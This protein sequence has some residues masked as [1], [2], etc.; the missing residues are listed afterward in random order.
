M[1][2]TPFASRSQLAA[3][4]FLLFSGL[5]MFPAGAWAQA[6]YFFSGDGKLGNP[7]ASAR[8]ENL[9]PRLKAL[10][11]YLQDRL[12]GGKGGIQIYS[13]YRSPKHNESLRRQGKLAAKASLHMEGMAAD[14]ALAGVPAERLWHF[15]RGLDCC[16]AGFYAGRMVHLDTGPPRFWEQETSKVWTDISAHNK[17]IYLTTDYDIYHPGE[18]LSFKI[19]RVTEYPFGVAR[20]AQILKGEKPWKEVAL[21]QGEECRGIAGGGETGPVS[22]RLPDGEGRE[23]LKLKISFCEKSSK[24]MPEFSTSNPFV[25]ATPE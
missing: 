21:D 13:G 22:L 4:L 15:I 14:F 24:E 11:D 23:K 16:G 5:A 10:L 8:L 7:K 19:V 1:I 3:A 2:S 25:I 20:K 17:Q 18:K 9:Q 6:R 12:T